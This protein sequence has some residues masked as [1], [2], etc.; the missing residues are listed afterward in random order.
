M[1]GPPDLGVSLNGDEQAGRYFKV[2]R[3]FL[4]IWF[5]FFA[6]KQIGFKLG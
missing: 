6:M 4:I 1:D 5:F 3:Y 2:E